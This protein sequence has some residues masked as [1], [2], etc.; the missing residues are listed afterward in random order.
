MEICR[1]CIIVHKIYFS[2]IVGYLSKKKKV[3][4]QQ[5]LMFNAY[6][7]VISASLETRSTWKEETIKL[8][9]DDIYIYAAVDLNRKPTNQSDGPHSFSSSISLH[10]NHFFLPC[11][12]CFTHTFT[13][14]KI[15]HYHQKTQPRRTLHRSRDCH[16]DRRKC[17]SPQCRFQTWPYSS[18][19]GS[20]WYPLESNNFFKFS[21]VN[22]VFC[23]A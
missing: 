3:R 7:K 13:Q 12:A 4:S 5:P 2:G 8:D 15:R 17:F 21:N 23:F 1:A 6:T 10:H 16:C 9:L 19:L 20:L 18:L 11:F 14:T 22:R